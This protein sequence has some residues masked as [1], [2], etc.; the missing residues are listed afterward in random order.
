MFILE[1]TYSLIYKNILR[2][3]NPLKKRVVKTECIVHQAINNQSLNILR[4]DGYFD[5]YN[6][7]STYID[8]I[9]AGVVW[10]DQDLKSSNHFYSPI[11]KRGLY[12]NSNA[13]NECGSY[14]NRALNEF[15]LGNKKEAMFYLGAAC[16]LIQ[17]VTIPQHA[18]VKLLK[19]HRSFENWIIKMYRRFHKFRAYNKGIYLNSIGQYIELN[20]RQA[21]KTHEKYSHIKNEH[22]R[23]YK[24]TSVIL[25]MA[26]KTTAGVMVK[27]FYDMQRLKAI[28]MVKL[29]K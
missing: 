29:Q 19:N 13:K 28:M 8:I 3:V 25:I 21:I 24:I 20:S 1:R 27:F 7:M 12:G 15:I 4:N 5:V 26:Q 11:T 2:A 14:Y 22:L 16:H 23:F 10:A 6:F 17:D 9:N 18:N